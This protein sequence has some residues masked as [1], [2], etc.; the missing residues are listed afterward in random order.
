MASGAV[1]SR[2]VDGQERLFAFSPRH[3]KGNV[4]VADT[5]SNTVWSQLGLGAVEGPLAGTPM[6][7]LPTIQ[8]SW[9]HWKQLYPT[10]TVASYRFGE[11]DPYRYAS[12]TNAAQLRR[13]MAGSPRPSR[14]PERNDLFLAVVLDGVAKAYPFAELSTA[15]ATVNDRI[16]EIEVLI[17]YRPSVPAAWVTDASGELLPSITVKR[18]GWAEFFPNAE[19]FR[20]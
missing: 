5:L 4:S 16:G 2:D 13:Q 8:T 10:T 1:S 20:H 18:Y 15:S 9:Q 14:E 6:A 12:R 17:H 3:Y 7:Q 11:V 19:V